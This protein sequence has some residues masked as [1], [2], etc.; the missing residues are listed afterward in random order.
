MSGLQSF[1]SIVASSSLQHASLPG[2]GPSTM[3]IQF[4][5]NNPGRVII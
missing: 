2:Q 3:P 5:G 4:V 1:N